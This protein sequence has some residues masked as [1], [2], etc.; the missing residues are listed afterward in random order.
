MRV[1]SLITILLAIFVVFALG[2]IVMKTPSPADRPGPAVAL[3]SVAEPTQAASSAET[4][5]TT[6][7][8]EPSPQAVA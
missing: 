4:Q 7:I 6:A 8:P 5:T 1:K 3:P 2:A